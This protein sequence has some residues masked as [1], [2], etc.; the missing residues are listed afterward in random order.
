MFPSW[1]HE[2]YHLS[3][4]QLQEWHRP[5]GGGCGEFSY[6]ANIRQRY[7]KATVLGGKRQSTQKKKKKSSDYYDPS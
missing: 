6:N 5:I 7:A 2:F 4:L 3:L 1:L